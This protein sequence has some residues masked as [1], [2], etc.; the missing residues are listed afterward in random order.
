MKDTI[1]LYDKYVD[2]YYWYEKSLAGDDEELPSIIQF[3]NDNAM[4]FEDLDEE[5]EM[6]ID[7]CIIKQ[8]LHMAYA[9][10]G[11]GKSYLG[12]GLSLRLINDKKVNKVVY[13][14]GD[15]SAPVMKNR[16]LQQI[17][18]KYK[19]FKLISRHKGNVQTD[20]LLKELADACIENNGIYKD[21]F[22]VFDSIRD[23]LGT[24]RDMNSDKDISPVITMLKDI[25]DKGLGTILF[26]HHT[27]RSDGS[28]K[29]SGAFLD[30]VDEGFSVESTRTKT[31]LSF[32]L[33]A[34]KRRMFESNVAFD[35]NTE[36][37]MELITEDFEKKQM[38]SVEVVVVE[39]AE[40]ILQ[41]HPQGL[42]QSAL[43]VA[44]E[45]KENDNTG[46]KYLQKYINKRWNA[47]RIPENNN[48]IMYY[49]LS[50][51]DIETLE[52]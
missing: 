49:P 36:G 12:V 37:E 35:L 52:T 28:F 40:D 17:V 26:L 22:F 39:Q 27:N 23:F 45:R 25:R 33:E 11:S 21:Y 48:A 51:N 31:G 6:L 43:L 46:I 19:N 10:P 20:L 9:P 47:Q 2:N 24:K 29:G 7:N 18:E 42:S 5:V 32:K 41:K 13:I 8:G 1:E 38:K 4:S 34:Q 15:N 16:G 30:K 14:D 44:M 3:I 50:K